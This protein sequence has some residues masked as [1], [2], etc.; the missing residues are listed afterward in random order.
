MWR[1]PNI[2]AAPDHKLRKPEFK[3]RLSLLDEFHADSKLNT[4]QFRGFYNLAIM[5][6]MLFLFTKPILNFIDTKQ[7]LSPTL[8]TIFKRDFLLCLGV[9]PL[10][11]LW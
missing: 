3:E 8:Y 6:G 2:A 4:S 10:F 5:F 1:Y 11:Y 9:W 7:F